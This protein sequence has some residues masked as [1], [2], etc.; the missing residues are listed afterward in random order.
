MARPAILILMVWS[1]V[2]CDLHFDAGIKDQIFGHDHFTDKWGFNVNWTD[3][4]D[5]WDDAKRQQLME[6]H[7]KNEVQPTIGEKDKNGTF[8]LSDLNQIKISVPA[9]TALGFEKRR[10]P[11]ELYDFILD[12]IC[13]NDFKPEHCPTTA[14]LNCARL[15][16]NG[17]RKNKA[18]SLH[19]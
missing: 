6:L 1:L 2:N 3:R 4:D 16:K 7:I 12:Q 18:Q 13:P 10:I 5:G 8:F 14:H 17:Y 9:L 15:D 11:I 19:G